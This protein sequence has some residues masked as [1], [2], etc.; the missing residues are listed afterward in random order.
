MVGVGLRREVWLFV[1]CFVRELNVDV[2]SMAS[3]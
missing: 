3:S 2:P 1:S